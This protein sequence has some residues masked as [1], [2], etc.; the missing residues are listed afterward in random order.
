M[1]IDGEPENSA[2]SVI[3]FFEHFVILGGCL[4]VKVT[5]LMVGHTHED[6]DSR[7][8]RIWVKIR[9][10]PIYIPQELEAAIREAFPFSNYEIN[11]IPVVAILNYKSYYEKF[12]DQ[13]VQN[14]RLYY[15]L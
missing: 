15:I 3:A 12:I 5:R 2:R 11:I 1:Q 7:F 4:K 6:I 8:G 13:D 9:Y 10:M 14:Y